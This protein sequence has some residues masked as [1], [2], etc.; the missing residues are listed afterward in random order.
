MD[1]FL[2]DPVSGGNF[3]WHRCFGCSNLQARGDVFHDVLHEKCHRCHILLSRHF[4]HTRIAHLS[5]VPC[6]GRLSTPHGLYD[7]RWDRVRGDEDSKHAERQKVFADDAASS[8]LKRLGGRWC[9]VEY[10]LYSQLEGV[11]LVRSRTQV[12]GFLGSVVRVDRLIVLR[13]CRCIEQSGTWYCCVELSI[14]PFSFVCRP[15]THSGAQST[16]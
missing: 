2:T 1:T 3:K 10:Q 9:E 7:S 15:V 16:Q 13:V 11:C 5:A 12:C 8:A 6:S 4:L 14:F